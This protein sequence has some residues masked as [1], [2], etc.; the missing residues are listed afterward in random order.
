MEEELTNTTAVLRDARKALRTAIARAKAVTWEDMLSELDR[1][2]WGRPYRID[3]WVGRPFGGLSYR[4]TQVLTGHGCFGEY[5]CRIKKEPTTRCHHCGAARDS[6]Q[7]TLVDC[8]AWEELRG[9][10]RAEIGN[11]LSLPAIISQMVGRESAWKAVSSFCEQVMLQKEEAEKVRERRPGGRMPP[12]NANS[13]RDGR[14]ED[15]DPTWLPPRPP[16]RRRT[17]PRPPGSSGPAVRRRRGRKAVAVSSSLPTIVEEREDE[18]RCSNAERGQ[19]SSPAAV[20]PAFGTRSRGRRVPRN[21]EP[22]EA[23]PT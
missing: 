21:S 2:P 7:H 3:E 23:D 15:H 18:N 10:L 11:D 20:G 16:R 13:G 12:G 8:P 4:T 5:L 22:G 1:E 14:D 17:A 6:A 19:P 9:V